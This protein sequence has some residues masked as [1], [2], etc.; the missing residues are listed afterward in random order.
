MRLAAL[1]LC[2]LALGLLAGAGASPRAPARRAPGDPLTARQRQ[3]IQLVGT[4]LTTKE[5]AAR[6]RISDASVRTH[7]RRACERLGVSSRAAAVAALSAKAKM[8]A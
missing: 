4:G 8:V 2:G 1:F 5:I 7:V 6:E 3:I